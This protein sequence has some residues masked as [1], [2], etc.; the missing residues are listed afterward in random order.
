MEFNTNRTGVE[1]K[2]YDLCT[3][4]LP[5]MGYIV[6]DLEYFPSQKL[7]RLYV[8]NPLTKTALIEDCVKVDHALT[9]YFESE[10]WM[11]DEITL[12]VSSPGAYRHV[13]D[14]EHLN[15][16]KNQ[17]VLC[18]IKGKLTEEQ[19]K[20]VPAKLKGEKK[21]RGKLVDFGSDFV[22]LSFKDG[23]IKLLA[24]QIKAMNV[25][26]DMR[27]LLDKKI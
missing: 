6:Y 15:L 4:V 19:L 16:A 26:P 5:A 10:T 21:F 14:M 9:P 11:P 27:D 3:D 12:E 7:F 8:M 25:D 18:V 24:E 2:F 20:Y 1:K 23:Q 17:D 13:R 22:T